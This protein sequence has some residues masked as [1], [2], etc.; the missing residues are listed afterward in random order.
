M[1]FT[2]QLP[3]Q[4]FSSS[5][6]DPCNTRLHSFLSSRVLYTDTILLYGLLKEGTSSHFCQQAE[7]KD[8]L[9]LNG[10]NLTF[11]LIKAKQSKYCGCYISQRA[12]FLFLT[13][14]YGEFVLLRISCH[15]E[16]HRV[17]GMG[18]MRGSGIGV[19]HLLGVPVVR[20]D[21]QNV[22]RFL[23]GFVNCADRCV[24][25]A[26]SFNCGIINSSV[27]NLTN[28]ISRRSCRSQ[29]VIQTLTM[30]GGAKLH[31]T[32]SCSPFFTSSATL[33][34]TPWTL[35]LGSLS[36]VAT[37]GDE[38]MCRSSF[39]NCFSTPPLKKNVT[40]AYFSVSKDKMNIQG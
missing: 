14:V 23:A 26:N 33:S 40:W 19:K 8:R 27:T 20:G 29:S 5:W 7:Q 22:T 21:E 28:G 32:N 6:R 24:C 13:F 2:L 25:F 10:I 4:F 36:Y 12:F 17:R 34:A 16:R 18:R 35:I 39:S 11:R 38:I 15:D 37:L 1:P 31:I 30:S 3:I 9:K